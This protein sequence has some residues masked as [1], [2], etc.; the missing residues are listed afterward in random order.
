ML[1][2]VKLTWKELKMVIGIGTDI[3]KIQRIRDNLD[4]G[5]DSF[6]NKSFTENE[7]RQAQKR[8]DPLLFYATRF[9]G[10]EAVFKCF[11]IDGGTIRLNEIE[12]LETDSGQPQ[13]SL[14][15]NIRDLAI[16]RGIKRI[17]ISLSFDTDYAIA[18]ALA[19][20]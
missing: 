8:P 4:T 1:M 2:T 15:G 18:F 9:S 20:G 14:L 5:G 3:L 12:I 19:E 7:R 16:A 11:G 6:F 13:V 10:K 17:Q